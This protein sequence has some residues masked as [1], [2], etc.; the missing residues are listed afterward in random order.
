MKRWA[1]SEPTREGCLRHEPMRKT[2]PFGIPLKEPRNWHVILILT[3]LLLFRFP[4]FLLWQAVDI[5]VI[6]HLSLKYF[7]N[8]SVNTCGDSPL[9]ENSYYSKT[10][11]THILDSFEIARCVMCRAEAHQ[12]YTRKPIFDAMGIQLVVLLTEH[13]D[14]EVNQSPPWSLAHC[15]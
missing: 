10:L 15:T 1:C 7:Q 4:S 12:L 3:T 6:L 9:G 11:T 8:T 14:G 2:Y 13:I 5:Y